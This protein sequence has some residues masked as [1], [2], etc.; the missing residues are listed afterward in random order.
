MDDV[1]KARSVAGTL[2]WAKRVLTQMP[3]QFVSD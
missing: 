3:R 2:L 1:K